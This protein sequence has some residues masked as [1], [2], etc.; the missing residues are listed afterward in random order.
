MAIPEAQ[1]ETWAHQGAITQSAATYQTV[2][3]AL[4]SS[5]A[6][7]AGRS[8]EIFLQGSYGNDTNIRDAESDV[9]IVIR[10][11]DS[12][13]HDLSALPDLQKA[14]FHKAYED[15]T[16]N[17]YSFKAD[18]IQQLRSHFGNDVKPGN[19]AVNIDPRGSRRPSDVLVSTLHRRYYKFNGMFDQNFD[20]GLTFFTSNG[21]RKIINYPKQHSA[22]LTTKHQT[23]G[24]RLKPLIRIFK[25][26]RNRQ[27]DKG[28]LEKG[29]A[30]SYFIEGMLYNV[31]TSSF[32]GTY[33]QQYTQTL[34]WLV[35]TDRSK[36][37][38]ANE[39]YY[40]L[41]RGDAADVAW[42][43]AHYLAYLSA[44]LDHYLNW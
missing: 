26:A 39:Q 28:K 35:N 43:E 19:K 25:N 9:D 4:T 44:M 18:V 33:G 20:P 41:D 38:C 30:P 42:N 3:N 36:L 10:L 31:P 15:A 37:V 11:D 2:R 24:N 21:G 17:F 5:N 23:T 32:S 8:F 40:L 16:Y 14:G 13:S 22:N 29:V 12:F 6:P 7:Y 27:I 34:Q 1:L